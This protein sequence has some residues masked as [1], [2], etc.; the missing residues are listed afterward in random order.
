MVTAMSKFLHGFSLV[1]VPMY[2]HSKFTCLKVKYKVGI[3][4]NEF[5]SCSRQLQIKF[6]LPYFNSVIAFLGKLR[7]YILNCT[8]E[9]PY[10]MQNTDNSCKNGKAQVKG[11]GKIWV[12]MSVT[13]IH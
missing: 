3:R 1:W 5:N 6:C 4:V 11:V 7:D 10:L 12:R 2:H 9:K 8:K 13:F